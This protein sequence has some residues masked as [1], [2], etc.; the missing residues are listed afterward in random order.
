MFGN[1]IVMPTK[2]LWDYMVYWSITGFIFM[3]DQSCRQTM[4]LRNLGRLSRLGKLNHFMQDFFRKWHESTQGVEANGTVDISQMPL[5]RESNQRLKD[6]MTNGQFSK[7]FG[8]NLAQLETLCCEIV[9]QSGL[10]VN[11]PFKRSTM[12][13]IRPGAFDSIFT[14]TVENPNSSMKPEL[15]FVVH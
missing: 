13:E 4:Y 14:N 7:Q 15:D 5:I 3:H 12:P 2:I 8:L 1:P 11:P 10:A 6:N 9:S